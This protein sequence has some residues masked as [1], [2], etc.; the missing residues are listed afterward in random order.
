ML[1][2]KYNVENYLFST[3]GFCFFAWHDLHDLENNCNTYERIKNKSCI[4][5]FEVCDV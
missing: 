2:I 4:A 3:W 5:S 1:Y